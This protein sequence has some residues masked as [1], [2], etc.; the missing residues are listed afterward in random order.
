MAGDLHT[1]TTFSDGSLSAHKLV[2][3]AGKKGLT[4]LAVSDHDSMQSILFGY[5]P[6]SYPGLSLIPASE[7]TAFDVQ[8]NRRVHILC[9]YPEI[10][11]A[12]KEFCQTMADRRNAVCHQSLQELLELYPDFDQE[13][14]KQFCSD[15]GVLYK[16]HLIRVLYEL[17]YTDGIYKELYK[18]LFGSK[19]GK[20]LHNP[21]Y[22]SVETVLDVIRQSKGVAV[23]AH[24]TVYNGMDLAQELAQKKL[25][26]GVEIYHP[27][28]TPQDQQTLQQLAKDYNLIITGGSDFHGMHST[29]PV[30]VGQCTTSQEQIQAIYHL[31][32]TRKGI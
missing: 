30:P 16:T 9:Y 8:R 22:E 28:N 26:D 23:L 21:P 5:Q 2:Q 12:L 10:S 20:V 6:S 25:I 29:R 19:G 1:H 27:R 4:H 11:S 7:L 31:A 13:M 15:S 14:A 3:A 18:E 32:Q 24:P 17:G